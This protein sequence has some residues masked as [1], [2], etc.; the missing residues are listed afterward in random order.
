MNKCLFL[1]I[2]SEVF[3]LKSMLTG[4]LNGVVWSPR[5]RAFMKQTIGFLS[6]CLILP[7]ES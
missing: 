5:Q 6:C 3:Q 2:A 4:V 7:L 1:I